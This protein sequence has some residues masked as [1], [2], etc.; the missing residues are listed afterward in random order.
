MK[1]LK[2]AP[3]FMVY[4]LS[5]AMRHPRTPVAYSYCPE[6]KQYLLNGEM[7]CPGCGRKLGNSPQPREISPVPWWGAVLVIVV[8]ISCWALGGYFNIAGLDEA[9]RALVYI[10]LGSLF[11][12]S[13][14]R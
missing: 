9:G 13:I 1:T 4:A 6:C 3:K 8:G 14:P 10:P 12:M 7:K 2:E 11:G 5:K